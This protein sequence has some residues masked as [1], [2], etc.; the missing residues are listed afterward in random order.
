M[1]TASRDGT[2]CLWDIDT[3]QRLHRLDHSDW[4]STIAVSAD[5]RR[6]ATAGKERIARIWDARTGRET[7]LLTHSSAGITSA[8]FSPD[9]A[10]VVTAGETHTAM[11][12]DSKAGAELA[13]S[14][15]DVTADAAAFAEEQ[16]VQ[17]A[18]ITDDG[19]VT[20]GTLPG[21][22][23][24]RLSHDARV[25]LVV[26]S[27][28]GSSV[29]TTMRGRAAGLWLGTDGSRPPR[30]TSLAH[31]TQVSTVAFADDGTRVVT[32]GQDGAVRVWDVAS[33]QQV[34]K[35][36]YNGPV[37]WVTAVALSREGRLA[38][39]RDDGTIQI[40]EP[41]SDTPD[42]AVPIGASTATALAFSPDGQ[43]LATTHRSNAA[44]VWDISDHGA[45]KPRHRLRHTDG[46][47]HAVVF[48]PDGRNMAT[49]GGDH[50]ARVWDTD[51]G[52][53]VVRLVHDDW[54]R[55][56]AFSPTGQRLVTISGAGAAHLWA[57]STELLIDQCTRR[58]C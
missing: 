41:G 48:S 21:R 22:P 42:S 57:I 11:V 12:W 30:F 37:A 58:T 14:A 9:G 2:A 53:E 38:V 15:D 3:G 54:V 28:D 49:A 27:P 5:N 35:Y 40:S 51:T 52:A 24:H 45:V 18:S 23:E 50:C 46:Y 31:D 56:L 20:I 7:A 39:G 19:Q 8:A 44:L 55:A 43:L 34:A 26:F 47:V 29:A 33:G 25:L 6:A 36:P 10:M 4:V 13:V 17:V 16:R 1:A 32:G